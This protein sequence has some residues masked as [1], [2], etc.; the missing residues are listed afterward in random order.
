[1]CRINNLQISENMLLLYRVIYFGYT[2]SLLYSFK[3]ELVFKVCLYQLKAQ[4]NSNKFL[5]QALILLHR[6]SL[7]SFR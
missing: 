4:L 7:C 2:I 3:I 1:M 5:I 6:E